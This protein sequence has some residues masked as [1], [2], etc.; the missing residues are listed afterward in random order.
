MTFRVEKP[1]SAGLAYLGEE[2]LLKALTLLVNERKKRSLIEVGIGDGRLYRLLKKTFPEH[3][4]LG[5]DPIYPLSVKDNIYPY[6]QDLIL[7]RPELINNAILIINW[8]DPNALIHYDHEAMLLLQPEHLLTIIETRHSGGD[9]RGEGEH[10]S[11]AGSI[12]FHRYLN[13][14]EYVIEGS[15]CRWG[16]RPS[17]LHCCVPPSSLDPDEEWRHSN[18]ILI[19]M[20]LYTREDLVDRQRAALFRQLI[21]PFDLRPFIYGERDQDGINPVRLSRMDIL[22]SRMD[23]LETK[24][25]MF[26][27]QWHSPPMEQ[28]MFRYIRRESHPDRWHE[29][30][31]DPTEVIY[32]FPDDDKISIIQLWLTIEH[33]TAVFLRLVLIKPKELLLQVNVKRAQALS[34]MIQRGNLAAIARYLLGLMKP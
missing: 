24:L 23:I 26:E 14:G 27:P 33:E 31:D 17:Y 18:E 1:W 28:E 2:P 20:V 10:G 11:T 5:V 6:L 34:L 22:D 4:C 21:S 29:S 32:P 13:S 9:G 3:E 30:D 8:P 16:E 25:L 7:D 12:A 19:E 15:R